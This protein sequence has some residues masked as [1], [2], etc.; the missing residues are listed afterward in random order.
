MT[1]Q[2]PTNYIHYDPERVDFTLTQAELDQLCTVG[3]NSWKD[4][5]IACAGAGVPCAINAA[6]INASMGVFSATFGFVLNLVVGILGISLAICFGIMWY[7][8]RNSVSTIVNR[9]K[10]KPKIAF[11]PP[12][13]TNVQLPTTGSANA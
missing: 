7:K 13:L 5:T 12:T 10:N 2:S 4:F 8:T 11:Q 1:T 3:Q 9:I 6:S